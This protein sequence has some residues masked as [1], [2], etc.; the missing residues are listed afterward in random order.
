[1]DM[2]KKNKVPKKSF[3]P[4]TNLFNTTPAS[5][6]LNL[7]QK[8]VKYVSSEYL[9]SE[10]GVTSCPIPTASD[11]GYCLYLLACLNYQQVALCKLRQTYSKYEFRMFYLTVIFNAL[12]WNIFVLRTLVLVMFAKCVLKLE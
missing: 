4:K 7:K 9:N 8:T 2:L 10:Q 12:A 11:L 5:K 1:M 6:I 3:R